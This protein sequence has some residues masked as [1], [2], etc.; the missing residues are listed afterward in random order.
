MANYIYIILIVIFAGLAINA[1]ASRKKYNTEVEQRNKELQKVQKDLTSENN[2]LRTK[3]TNLGISNVE[4]SQ[5][6]RNL[7]ESINAAFVESCA[8]STS[9]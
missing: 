3:N 9:L 2:N 8:S 6:N 5:K 1:F 4:L 7:E